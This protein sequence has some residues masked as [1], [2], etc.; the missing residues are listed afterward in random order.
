MTT[1][2]TETKDILIL[3]KTYPAPSQKYVETSCT[4]GITSD[5]T[6]IRIYPIPFRHLESDKQ[7]AKWQWVRAN[8]QI[9]EHDKRKESRK[10]DFTSL[11]PGVTIKDWSEK[12][13]WLEKFPTFSTID[14]INA[15]RETQNISLAIIKPDR[16][17]DL[18]FRAENPEWDDDQKR[19]LSQDLE[20]DLF[21]TGLKT[22]IE[23]RLQKLPFGFYYTFT[24]NGVR[25]TARVTDWEIGMLYFN[26]Q[27]S[28]DWQ[29]KMRD[30]YVREFNTK[31][32]YLI[33]GNQHRFQDQ[34]LIIG[35]IAA[36]KGTRSSPEL[37]FDF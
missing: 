32:V 12:I 3:V 23:R 31:D 29:A 6:P 24:C 14:E 33:F 28:S 16:I 35:I 20:C 8:V 13:K 34:W 26:T 36:P 25:Q 22:H 21:A 5:G 18:E 10:A 17:D 7:Y 15:A 2:S 9:N 30:K 19:K 11:T 4:A 37:D 27:K 1:L